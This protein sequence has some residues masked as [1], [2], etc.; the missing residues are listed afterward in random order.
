[1]ENVLIFLFVGAI[2][3]LPFYFI[4]FSD[5]TEQSDKK[6][7]LILALLTSWCAWLLYLAYAFVV[8]LKVQKPI[9]LREVQV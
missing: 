2:Y 4:L 9:R 7:F 6:V 3:Q 1:M 8:N 5:R